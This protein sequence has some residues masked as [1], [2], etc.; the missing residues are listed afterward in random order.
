[1]TAEKEEEL[2]IKYYEYGG[3]LLRLG[4]WNSIRDGGKD[5][6]DLLFCL[7]CLTYPLNDTEVVCLRLKFQ[8]VQCKYVRSVPER[9]TINGNKGRRARERNVKTRDR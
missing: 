2:L 9:N 5:R 8:R 3:L 7:R 4:H 6:V 1:M